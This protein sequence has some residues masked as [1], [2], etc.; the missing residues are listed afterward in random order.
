ML[1]S[2]KLILTIQAYTVSGPHPTA[3]SARFHG[4]SS[5]TCNCAPV[6]VALLLLPRC[7]RRPFC[8]SQRRWR[9]LDICNGRPRRAQGAEY[10]VRN[11]LCNR[12]DFRFLRATPESV[13]INSI[14]SERHDAEQ[15]ATTVVADS[16]GASGEPRATQKQPAVAHTAWSYDRAFEQ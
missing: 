4:L 1:S 8:V 13:R 5:R 15:K 10:F 7:R 9:H 11:T 2:I 6:S 14:A 16:L 3:G 12:V